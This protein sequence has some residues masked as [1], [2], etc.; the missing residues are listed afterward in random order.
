[1]NTSPVARRLAVH[2]RVQGV[3]FRAWVRRQAVAREV[4]GWA[5][6]EPDGSVEVWLQGDAAAVAAVERAVGHGPPHARV[7]RVEAAD[8]A[9][10][11]DVRGFARH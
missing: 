7:D 8:A 4:D 5:A 10:R 9:P 6:N 1:V 3:N 2:G 11:D